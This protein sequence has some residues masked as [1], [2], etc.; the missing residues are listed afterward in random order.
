MDR[1]N[2]TETDMVL[3]LALRP[4]IRVAVHSHDQLR[5]VAGME[6][7][8]HYAFDQTAVESVARMH[9]IALTPA[10]ARDL[11]ILQAEGLQI[12]REQA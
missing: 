10:I 4:A 11:G 2:M 12:M 5:T 9:R 8:V 1:L 7:A 6:G 3:P